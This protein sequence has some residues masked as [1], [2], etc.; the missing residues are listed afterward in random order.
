[1]SMTPAVDSDNYIRLPTHTLEGTISLK[2]QSVR[3]TDSH[4]LFK[5]FFQWPPR[6]VT[7]AVHLV[8]ES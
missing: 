7:P 5:H 8:L 6:S 3:V 2:I 1:M 4:L